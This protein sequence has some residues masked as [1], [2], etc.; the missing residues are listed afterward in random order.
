M[1]TSSLVNT[2]LWTS[3]SIALITSTAIP[4]TFL[5]SVDSVIFSLLEEL[6][7]LA[8][9]VLALVVNMVSK[10]FLLTM[11][12]CCLWS[13]LLSSTL[14]SSSVNTDP[15]MRG[16]CC[17]LA[18]LLTL[19]LTLSLPF[20]LVSSLTTSLAPQNNKSSVSSSSAS[21]PAG[22][23]L[24]RVA[25][26]TSEVLHTLPSLLGTLWSLLARALST[27]AT[28]NTS[29]P[30]SAST[31]SGSSVTT[32]TGIFPPSS[33]MSHFFLAG[34]PLFAPADGLSPPNPFLLEAVFPDTLLGF[35]EPDFP[36]PFLLVL[37]AGGGGSASANTSPLGDWSL[38]LPH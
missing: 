14:S 22:I 12:W 18:L 34:L 9:T 4:S 8:P 26:E 20:L 25:R 16:V 35:P 38:L 32:I 28:V 23:M 21:S 2:S 17:S 6:L 11:T 36:F 37:G 7:L 30:T 27:S 24:Q 10:L 3:S 1:P 31:M 29:S 33:T 15:V 19:L 13:V 5:D